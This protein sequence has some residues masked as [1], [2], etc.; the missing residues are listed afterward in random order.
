MRIKDLGIY[1]IPILMGIIA[2]NQIRMAHFDLLSPWMG[3]GFGMFAA[4]NAPNVRILVVRGFTGEGDGKLLEFLPLELESTKLSTNYALKLQAYPNLEG[5]KKVSVA[6]A[7]T[8]FVKR[9]NYKK[10]SV[11][12][13]LGWNYD[14]PIYQ[15]VNSLRLKELKEKT[16]EFSVVTASIYEFQYNK[17]E[18]SMQLVEILKYRHDRN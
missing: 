15:P 18:H 2:I 14:D 4:N 10:H 13:S 16:F 1:L 5:L 11:A 17:S 6:M 8:K 3:G 9:L 12:T 7:N